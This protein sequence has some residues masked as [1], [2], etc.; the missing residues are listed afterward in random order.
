[1]KNKKQKGFTLAELVVTIAIIGIITLV[2]SFTITTRLPYYKVNQALQLLE[3]DLNDALS[4]SRTKNT[5]H[6]L[7]FHDFISYTVMSEN[8]AGGD[9]LTESSKRTVNDAIKIVRGINCAQ[10]ILDDDF[11]FHPGGFIELKSPDYDSKTRC[12]ILVYHPNTGKTRGITLRK[13]GQV[14]IEDEKEGGIVTCPC[15]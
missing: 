15:P 7:K 12:Q 9:P 1:M 3:A 5:T 11:A 14:I 10:Q 6:F 2:A 4:G 8:P 13:G